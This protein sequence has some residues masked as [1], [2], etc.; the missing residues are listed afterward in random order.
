VRDFFQMSE[1]EKCL[2]LLRDSDN[3]PSLAFTCAILI[4]RVM[5]FACD[6]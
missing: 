1:K 6:A 5:A 2:V 4:V 3:D